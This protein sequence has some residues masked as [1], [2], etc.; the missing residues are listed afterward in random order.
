MTY[1]TQTRNGKPLREVEIVHN[2][3]A[4]ATVRARFGT[5]AGMVYEVPTSELEGITNHG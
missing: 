1:A 3:G 2:N 4:T 5:M